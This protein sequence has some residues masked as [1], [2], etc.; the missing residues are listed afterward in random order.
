MLK[1][2]LA[3]VAILDFQKIIE[4][5]NKHLDGLIRNIPTKKQFHQTCS[6]REEDI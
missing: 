1:L 2:C 6:F 5:H 4:E 3:V